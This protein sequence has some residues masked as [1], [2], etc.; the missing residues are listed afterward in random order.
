VYF[1]GE[2]S[3]DDYHLGYK[4]K[5]LKITLLPTRILFYFAILWFQKFAEFLKN[6]EFTLKE[7]QKNTLYL[8]PSPGPSPV[9]IQE[10]FFEGKVATIQ[11][12]M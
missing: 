5:F 9:F 10:I 7:N 6:L 12:K 1:I 11:R 8:P 3:K 4:Q 2:S